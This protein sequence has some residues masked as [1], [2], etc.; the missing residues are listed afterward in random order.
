M[1][2]LRDRVVAKDAPFIQKRA[3]PKSASEVFVRSILAGGITGAINITL[4]YPTEFVKTQLQLDE[5]KKVYKPLATQVDL[6][7][8][9]GLR[10]RATN[11]LVTTI[12]LYG[13]SKDVIKKT[14]DNKGFLGLYKG[15]NVLI[16]G[17]VP[18]YAV[19]FGFFDALKKQFAD[20]RGNLSLGGR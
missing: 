11:L 1:S 16:F 5:G 3:R 20:E 4:V 10:Y 6:R 15:C 17:S 9:K 7:Q 12:K 14:L 19:R 2:L 18:M 13:G 8:A